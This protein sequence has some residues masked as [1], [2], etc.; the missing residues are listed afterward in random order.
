MK[1]ALIFSPYLDTLGGGE[2]YVLVV[3]SL[4][5]LRKWE[6]GLCWHD[7]QILSKLSKRFGLSTEGIN[8]VSKHKR[9]RGYNLVFWLSDGSIPLLFG[10]RNI[11][12]FQTP[13]HAV[14]GRSIINQLK[15][16][17]IHYIICNSKFT[18]KWID[19]EYGVD[20]KV[21]YPPVETDK[22]IAGKKENTILF[23]GRFS[24]LQQEKRQDILIEVFKQLQ[25][26]LGKWRLLLA[27][28]SDVGR[29]NYVE[30]LKESARGYPIKILENV[31]YTKMLDLYKKSKIFWS[32]SGFEVDEETNPEKVE[33]F[34]ISVV[35]AMAAGCVPVIVNIGGH[36]EIVKN[37]ENG[38][39]WES[40]DELKHATLILTKD[41]Q[42]RQ[43]IAQKARE[44]AKTFS[45]Q[46]FE[47]K[48][49]EVI[50]S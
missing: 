10:R 1:K 17:R 38:F 42:T 8:I 26:R 9:G 43:K 22:F 4:L 21:I 37:K 31:S 20:S 24:Q 25:D 6:V 41:D 40:I 29:T 30:Q 46:R 15:L 45:V 23:V 13:F 34:G 48:M 27:G 35:E 16:K 47:T 7:Q 39:L 28:G 49:L 14:G 2:R 12:H 33:H 50:N 36:K 19:K 44:R 5:N 18:K 32:A 3:G 11:L